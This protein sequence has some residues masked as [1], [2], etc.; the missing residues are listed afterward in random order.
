MLLRQLSSQAGGG[1]GFP[2]LLLGFSQSHPD[3]PPQPPFM[4]LGPQPSHLLAAV[5]PGERGKEGVVAVFQ[6]QASVF[7]CT[8][9]LFV[10]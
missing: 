8:F 9:P 6:T 3:P 5:A 4:F 10:V 1:M 7:I 2:L